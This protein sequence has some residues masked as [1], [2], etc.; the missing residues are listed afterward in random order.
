MKRP[1]DYRHWDVLP[2]KLIIV[3]SAFKKCSGRELELRLMVMGHRFEP[4]RRH[5]VVSLIKTL[6]PLPCIGL[7]KETS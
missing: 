1:F 7:T 4:H 6:Y 2:V 5:C 3:E